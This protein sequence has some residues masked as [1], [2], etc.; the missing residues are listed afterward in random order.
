MTLREQFDAAV[1][2]RQCGQPGCRCAK[3][4]RADRATVH[5]PLHPDEHPSLDLRIG[6]RRI[7]M[8]CRSQ[9]CEGRKI[10]KYFYDQGV[11][12]E[13]RR[14]GPRPQDDTAGSGGQ[15]AATRARIVAEYTY[16]DEDG[17]ELFQTVRYEPKTFKQRRPDGH[18]GWIWNR[19]DVRLVPYRLPELLAAPKDAW[20]FYPE[21]EGDVE[22]LRGLGLSA[23]TNPL[24]AEKMRDEYI[25]HFA[26][27][28]VAICEDHDQAGARDVR[29]KVKSLTGA[30]Q[31]VVVLRFPDLPE[32]G[33]ISDWIARERAAGRT[34]A[35]I[36]AALIRLADD[37][38]PVGAV[39]EAVGAN[40]ETDAAE[41]TRRSQ[42]TI[43]TELV[44]Q[45]GAELFH[46]PDRTGFATV[47]AD[48]HRETWRIK[49]TGMR[50]W[51]RHRYYTATGGSP[52][53]QAVTDALEQL[54][55]QALFVGAEHPVFVRI[56]E[57]G[58]NIYVDM[59]NDRWEVI[60]V[61]SDGWRVLP[62]SPVRFQRMRGTL[63]LPY[64]TKGGKLVALRRFIHVETSTDFRL[65]LSWL[66]MAL[67]PRGPYPPLIFEGPQGSAKS[68]AQRLVRML[69]DP[70][71]TPLRSEPKEVRD[72]MIAA[73]NG[74][75]AGFDNISY[76]GAWL[77]DALCRLAT[78]AGFATRAL[79][80]DQDEVLLSAT[81]PVLLNGIV[82]PAVR[83]DL[84]ERSL[85]FCL[86]DLSEEQR[87]DE[88]ELLAEFELKR[89]AILGA[90]LTVLS[91]ALQV[92][93]RLRLSRK[94]RMADFAMVGAAAARALGWTIRDFL[95]AYAENRG[96]ANQ[97]ALEASP[98]TAP[99]L[100][101]LEAGSFVGTASDLLAKLGMKV[102][103]AVRRR[104]EWPG[105]ASILGGALRRLAPSI[106]S[107]G[108]VVTFRRGKEG[109]I[110]SLVKVGESSSPSSPSLAQ[111]GKT[112]QNGFSQTDL[113]GDAPRKERRHP[114]SPSSPSRDSSTGKGDGGRRA[115]D[116]PMSER[117][118]P[119]KSESLYGPRQIDGLGDEGD[120]EIPT[121]SQEAETTDL[122]SGIAGGVVDRKIAEDQ[123]QLR[124][125]PPLSASAFPVLRSAL[126]AEG[127]PG[128]ITG[129]LAP[130]QA[131]SLSELNVPKSCRPDAPDGL[132]SLRSGP[133]IPLDPRIFVRA[134]RARGEIIHAILLAR[135]CALTGLSKVKAARLISHA[136]ASGLLRKPRRL[137]YILGPDVKGMTR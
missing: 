128:R 50:L 40:A 134:F 10:I 103:E 29:R 129:D 95:R 133:P 68:L 120:G 23:T 117:A 96:E 77:S 66:V 121:L 125:I 93:P 59:A 20:I 114:S 46:T 72:L 53:A 56:G 49:S 13:Q 48:G 8:I 12:A 36:R 91:R 75:I 19:R 79:Y 126:D 67:W 113:W 62:A 32:G 76:L 45:S 84:L 3:S 102:E 83:P 37:A 110:L 123:Q 82:N 52:Y 30:A 88:T 127:V 25:P 98:L 112:Q 26:G 119:R 60:E 87:R 47:P 5:C 31:V 109:R 85:I 64:P 43:L 111:E 6:E 16:C 14:P 70:H 39:A 63:P 92:R 65:V 54:E 131:S 34:D 9:H 105:N 90:L 108:I 135:V 101:L 86:P 78:G 22:A 137:V 122:T 94:P 24:G 61:R 115:G 97:V 7:L 2:D 35:D 116:G 99:I 81:R 44:L 80:L 130:G 28:K 106:R 33:D 107:V 17:H 57:A 1:R 4:H 74:W 89:P 124:N 55:S 51:L 136:V 118:S 132:A 71:T 18:G 104:K 21:G 38:V 100:A 73:T 69:I 27:R 15:R 11:W 42:A 41:P 58:G